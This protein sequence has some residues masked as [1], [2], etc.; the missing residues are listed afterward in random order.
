MKNAKSKNIKKSKV[1]NRKA[2]SRNQIISHPPSL[3][4][5]NVIHSTRL[6]FVTGAAIDATITFQNLLDLICVASSGTVLNDLFVA[7]K[8]RQV[9]MWTLPALGTSTSCTLTFDANAAGF[10]GNQVTHTDASMGI[11]PAHLRV[12]PAKKSLTS[13]FQVSSAA[14]AFRLDVPTGT[15]ID[16]SLSFK[17][18][19]SAQAL[20]AQNVGAALTTGGIYYRGLDG[21]AVAASNYKLPQG[22]AQA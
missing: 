22:I 13:M 12:S 21:V 6:R 11:E 18:S 16:V 19:T 10:V 7:V 14:I 4:S 20:A 17:G 5:F 9:E 15:V 3:S 2:G 8:L 1:G